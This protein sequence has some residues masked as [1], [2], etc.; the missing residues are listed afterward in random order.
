[1]PRPAKRH[2]EVCIQVAFE[3]AHNLR[4]YKGLPEPLHGHSWRVEAIVAGLPDNEGLVMDFLE[5][6][7]LL[8]RILEPLRHGYINEVP[9]FDRINPSAENIAAWI[10]DQLAPLVRSQSR[11][12]QRVTVWEG[13]S[14]WASCTN[15]APRKRGRN[16]Y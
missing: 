15:F 12:L 10:F 16:L 6:E 1:M 8:R 13:A 2:F 4:Q 5:A 7:Q 14:A 3:A 9:P 11:R